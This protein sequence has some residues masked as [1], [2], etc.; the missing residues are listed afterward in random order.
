MRIFAIAPLAIAATIGFSGVA[1]A[2]E[3][4]TEL[5]KEAYA[6]AAQSAEIAAEHARAPLAPLGY[7]S[8]ASRSNAVNAIN[9]ASAVTASDELEFR[10]GDRG[11]GNN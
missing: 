3:Y 8:A 10:I 7:A 11:I 2:D 1:L 4:T 9:A 5:N 6:V